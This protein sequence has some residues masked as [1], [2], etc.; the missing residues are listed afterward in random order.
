MNVIAY[1]VIEDYGKYWFYGKIADEHRIKSSFQDNSWKFNVFVCLFTICSRYFNFV[2]TFGFLR[3]SFLS[4][5]SPV[6]LIEIPH[7]KQKVCQ[8]KYGIKASV[9]LMTMGNNTCSV[10]Q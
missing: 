7:K 4:L 5:R 2:S 6:T 8:W 9:C 1:Q 3:S 10:P